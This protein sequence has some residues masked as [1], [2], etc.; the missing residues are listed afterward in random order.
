[1]E[2]EVL[3]FGPHS[4]GVKGGVSCNYVDKRNGNEY[5]ISC[6]PVHSAA[7]MRLGIR[8][9]MAVFLIE[10]GFLDLK[11]EKYYGE[12]PTAERMSEDALA[13][14]AKVTESVAPNP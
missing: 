7:D 3:T 14:V 10:G 12:E 8:Y 9:E 13:I 5:W 4:N 6:I 11:G 2:K 1:M